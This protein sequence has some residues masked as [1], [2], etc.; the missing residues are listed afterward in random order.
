L[1]IIF[2]V[3]VAVL[4]LGF[5]TPTVVKT[6][7]EQYYAAYPLKSF[8][9]HKSILFVLGCFVKFVLIFLL[10]LPLIFIPFINVITL[11]IPFFYLFYKLL[12]FDVISNMFDE[13][14]YASNIQPIRH[15]LVIISLVF[16]FLALIPIIGLF[17]QL[18]FAIYLTHYIFSFLIEQQR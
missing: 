3:I 11:H 6:L 1:V 10:C 5:F 15:H 12:S 9:T 7:H 2:S 8:K 4:A 14:N 13:K 16:Y 18:F 17:L